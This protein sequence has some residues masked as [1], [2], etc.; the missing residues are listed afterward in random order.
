MV[1]SRVR[2]RGTRCASGWADAGVPPWDCPPSA[3]LS[4]AWARS[5][6][7]ARASPASPRPPAALLPSGVR[8]P[9]WSTACTS[10][11]A[12]YQ[13]PR[14]PAVALAKANPAGPPAGSASGRGP[15]TAT[16]TPT[17]A[18]L[19]SFTGLSASGDVALHGSD[20]DVAP[21]DSQVGVGP[22]Q[23]VLVVNS[24]MAV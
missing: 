9:W 12:L 5:R 4:S 16:P 15:L 19:T 21:P 18:Q 22:T 10:T 1:S 13:R 6:W 2:R 11:C 3:V 7:R 14:P 23:V 8:L 24:T 17:E 20:Q